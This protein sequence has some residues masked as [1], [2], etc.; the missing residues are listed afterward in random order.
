LGIFLISNG[1]PTTDWSL[2]NVLTQIGLGYPF[3]FLLWRRSF[4]TQAFAAGVLLVGTYLL[5]ALYPH[6]GINISQG[7]PEVGISHKWAQESLTGV[8][9]A[10]HKNANAGH[11]I[12]VWL[13]NYLPHKGVTGNHLQETGVFLMNLSNPFGSAAV[14][15]YYLNEAKEEFRY[16][17]GGYQTIN[18]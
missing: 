7:A 9:S 10:W 12:D 13:L 16:N 4:F 2:M 1:R 17:R 15:H 8:G 18:F 6:S 3:L 14:T 5:Y 11:H